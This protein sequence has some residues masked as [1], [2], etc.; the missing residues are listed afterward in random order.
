MGRVPSSRNTAEGRLE[1]ASRLRRAQHRRDLQQE[2]ERAEHDALAAHYGNDFRIE[3]EALDE[4]TTDP[5][6]KGDRPKC[7]VATHAENH[8]IPRR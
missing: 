8:S 1:R 7:S 2:I 4:S 3:A 5:V 6:M